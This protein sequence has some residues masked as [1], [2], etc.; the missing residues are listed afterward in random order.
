MDLGILPQMGGSSNL[1]YRTTLILYT[2]SAES[3]LIGPIRYFVFSLT[4]IYLYIFRISCF[5]FQPYGDLF[6]PFLYFLL[7]M[8]LL[9]EVFAAENLCGSCQ[10]LKTFLLGYFCF[11]VKSESKQHSTHHQIPWFMMWKMPYYYI[12]IH[13]YNQLKTPCIWYLYLV[14]NDCQNTKLT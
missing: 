8:L 9:L 14:H 10:E 4:E 2:S 11:L 1:V 6:L 13:T 7:S 12:W 3:S 5:C